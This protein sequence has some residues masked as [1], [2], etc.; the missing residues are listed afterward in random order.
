MEQDDNL[1]R[2]LQQQKPAQHGDMKQQQAGSADFQPQAGADADIGEGSYKATRDYQ[3]NIKDYL[4][5]ADVQAD[6]ERAK[7]RSEQ[8]ARELER[9]EREGRSHSKGER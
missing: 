7:P 2:Q 5:D 6:A 3:K 4:Q 1:Q 9:A 8:E